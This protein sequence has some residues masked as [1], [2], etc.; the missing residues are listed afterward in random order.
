MKKFHTLIILSIAV[1]C[2][3]LSKPGTAQIDRGEIK[4]KLSYNWI[5]IYEHYPFVDKDDIERYKYNWGNQSTYNYYA[6]LKFDSISSRY[7][8]IKESQAN[9]N[10]SFRRDEFIIYRNTLENKT[11]DYLRLLNKLTVIEDSIV[12]PKWKINNEMK[13]IAGY[14]CMNASFQ[15]TIKNNNITA[16]FALNFPYPYGPER[17]GGLPG[18]ILEVNINNGALIITAEKITAKDDI[19][20]QKP[21]HR[22]RVKQLKEDEY[23]KKI[24]EYISEQ[25]ELEIPYYN[26]LRFN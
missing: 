3:F 2:L 22:K 21:K 20:I 9:T 10:W 18:I 19:I 16:W 13:E 7:E 4:Y 8:D 12:Y 26:A 6:T 14:I 5:K 23:K 11:Y 24:Y 17:Y 1:S 25:R 15:D